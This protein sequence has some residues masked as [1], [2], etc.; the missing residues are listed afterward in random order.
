MNTERSHAC[1]AARP[2][3]PAT[4]ELRAPLARANRTAAPTKPDQGKCSGRRP[5]N[6]SAPQMASSC[7]RWIPAG[8]TRACSDRARWAFL[9]RCQPCASPPPPLVRPPKHAWPVG[10]TSQAGSLAPVTSA[11]GPPTTPAAIVM[12]A[13]LDLFAVHR[14]GLVTRY[15]LKSARLIWQ[16]RAEPAPMRCRLSQ[17]AP[18]GRLLLVTGSQARLIGTVRHPWCSHSHL[19]HFTCVTDRT[20][21]RWGRRLAPRR[22]LHAT[23]ACHRSRAARLDPGRALT[24]TAALWRP[25]R[26]PRASGCT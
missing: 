7:P 17:L 23:V 19:L 10:N 15:N 26:A 1:A 20:G 18:R 13:D 25:P 4:A 12:G 21:A 24:M 16:V 5:V 3:S 22:H 11:Y 6:P 14:T 8:W 2:R 9:D